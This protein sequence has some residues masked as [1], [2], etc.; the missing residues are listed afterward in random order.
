M[1]NVF[2]ADCVRF[3]SYPLN[4]TSGMEQSF[5]KNVL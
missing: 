4:S 2:L 3:R 1:A 5:E